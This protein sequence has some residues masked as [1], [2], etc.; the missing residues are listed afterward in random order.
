[1]S[2]YENLLRSTLSASPDDRN[3]A[4]N[5]MNN[6]LQTDPS[7]FTMNLLNG[8]ALQDESLAQLSAVLFRRKILEESLMERMSP[9]CKQACR[10]V[11]TLFTANRSITFLK[12]LADCTLLLAISEHFEGELLNSI[13]QWIASDVPQLREVAVYIFELAT[14]HDETKQFLSGN[15][16]AAI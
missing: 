9:E 1:M 10:G 4:E 14:E 12:N 11:I 5:T 2:D 6:M 8:M 7:T 3:N 13:T 15:I 16:D